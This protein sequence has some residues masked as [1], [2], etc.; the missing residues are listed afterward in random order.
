MISSPSSSLNLGD[1][2]IRDN[3]ATLHS[4]SE[5]R[6][7]LSSP[8]NFN[9]FIVQ[10]TTESSNH[11][12]NQRKISLLPSRLAVQA[13]DE[14]SSRVQESPSLLSALESTQHNPPWRTQ[15]KWIYTAMQGYKSQKEHS[16]L[17]IGIGLGLGIGLSSITQQESRPLFMDSPQIHSNRPQQ[18]FSIISLSS[19][20]T[21]HRFSVH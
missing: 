8:R 10:P 6:S 20:S 9:S 14:D 15:W 2:S 21:L 5:S 7:L 19:S 13:A 17:G 4:Y 16:G 12:L 3:S 11:T 18:V 1:I